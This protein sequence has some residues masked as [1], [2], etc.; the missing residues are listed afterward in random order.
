[1]IGPDDLSFDLYPEES[2]EQWHKRRGLWIG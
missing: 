1:V 2:I